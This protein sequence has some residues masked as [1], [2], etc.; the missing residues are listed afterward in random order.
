MGEKGV[1]RKKKNSGDSFAE[2]CRRILGGLISI[3]LLLWVTVFPLI[4]HDSYFDILVTKYTCIYLIILGMLGAAAI[5]SLVF[6]F[7][8]GLEY[9]LEHAKAFFKKLA[10]RNW[11]NI[12]CLP[13][14]IIL[15]FW[16]VNL[17]STLQSDYLYESFWGNEGRYNG[18]FL[19]TL[20]VAAYFLIT[21]LWKPKRWVLEVFILSGLLICFFGIGDFFLLDPLGL[22]TGV[23]ARQKELFTSTLGNINSYTAYVGILMGLTSGLFSVEKNPFRAAW[24]YIATVIAMFAIVTGYSENAYLSLAALLGLMPLL[25]FQS[26][27]GIWRYS[28]LLATFLGIVKVVDFIID[29]L[30]DQTLGTESGIFDTIARFPM[31]IPVIILLLL[32]SLFLWSRKRKG[33]LMGKKKKTLTIAWAV[34]IV[35]GI[36]AIAAAL[37]DV[38]VFGNA[39]RY[40]KAFQNYLVFDDHWG[41]ERGYIWKSSVKL[42]AA[43]PLIRKLFG[44]G[45]DTFGILTINEIY[46]EMGSTTGLIFDSAHNEYLQYMVTIGFLGLGSYLAFLGT[47]LKKMIQILREHEW[48]LGLITGI[49]C[50]MVQA[51]VNFNVPIVAPI[52]WLMIYIGIAAY[53]NSESF[54]NRKS[55]GEQGAKENGAEAK[56]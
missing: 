29:A 3:G 36:I 18:L 53:R 50:Y 32:L 1:K 49:V 19:M 28:I 4:L 24:Y 40:P 39:A 54:K 31:L 23:N 15:A 8:D 41:T 17:I 43:F 7:I 22:K 11:K 38:N 9:H 26:E 56:S 21:R 37:V 42:M 2:S 16:V 34:L 33:L 47:A 12:F 10:P 46:Y 5:F 20:Y 52:F 35:I 44:Y 45:P 14:V 48:V 30:P 51:L 55:T 25:F 6:I 13:D 27:D